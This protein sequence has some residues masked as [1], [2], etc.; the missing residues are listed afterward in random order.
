M[1]GI[2]GETCNNIACKICNF[3]TENKLWVSEAHIPDKN[4]IAADQQSGILQDATESKLH[5]ELFQKIVDKFGKPDI[6]L[7]ASTI[8]RKL[9]RYASW[10]PEPEVIAVHALCLTWDNNFFTCSQLLVLQVEH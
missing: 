9:K 4:N 5:P 8:S 2:K 1:G 3:W 7:F 10:H 6:A